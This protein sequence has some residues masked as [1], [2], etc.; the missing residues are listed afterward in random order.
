MKRI[1]NKWFMC[2]ANS[3]SNPYTPYIPI[4]F[5]TFCIDEYILTSKPNRGN[6]YNLLTL[7]RSTKTLSDIQFGIA[8]FQD[9]EITT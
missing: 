6:I 9:T 4:P 8:G 3:D 1:A 5:I 7:A 2:L